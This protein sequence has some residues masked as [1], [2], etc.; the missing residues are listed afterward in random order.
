VDMYRWDIDQRL[1]TAIALSR[2]VRPTSIS[3]RH[4]ARVRYNEDGSVSQAFSAWLRGV[5]PDSW[6][7]AEPQYRDWLIEEEMAEVKILFQHMAALT[8]P[9]R[10]SRAFWYHEYA[11]RTYYGEV[12]WVLV[13]TALESLLNT[14]PYHSGAQFRG[15]VP[16][17]A[18]SVHVSMN[19]DEARRAW[20]MRSHLSHGGATGQL[21]PM[22]EEIYRKL[23]MLLRRV[24]KK[25]ILDG[26]FASI[27]ADD[28]RIRAS[29]PI[30]LSG[31]S[32]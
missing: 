18:S 26:A 22:E 3:F 31:R 19:E 1:Q 24:L 11:A 32:I 6:L 14:D 17:V 21:N 30:I 8:L 15:R 20:S 29:W 4:A 7:P 16:L 12:R 28:D 10:V 25:A 27:F 9:V 5:D 2:L 13:C 23:E